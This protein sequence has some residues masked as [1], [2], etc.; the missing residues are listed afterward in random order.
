MSEEYYWLETA[1]KI[2][3]EVALKY[4]FFLSFFFL[5]LTDIFTLLQQSHT[6]ALCTYS[7][8]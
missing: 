4:G 8:S 3:H 5:L 7:H 2:P 6:Q 1:G